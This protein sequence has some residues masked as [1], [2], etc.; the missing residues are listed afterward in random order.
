L[1]EIEIVGGGPAGSAAA[2][3]ALADG[4]RVRIYEKSV[5]PRHRVCGEFLSPEIV[6]VFEE[7]GVTSE[8]FA[9]K[10]A[11]LKRIRLHFGH[12]TASCNLDDPAFG[13]SRYS[14]DHLLLRA[15]A[16]RGAAID[17]VW[18]E[19]RLPAILAHGR[20]RSGP[21]GR[22][23]FGFKAHFRGS[24]DDAVDLFFFGRSYAGVSAVENGMI[25][26]CGL[27]PEELFRT[28]QFDAGSFLPL[29][30]P[31]NER[32]QAMSQVSDWLI[33]GPLVF[34]DSFEQGGPPYQAGDALGFTD[35]F[36]G[37]GI[38]AAVLTGSMAGTAAARGHSFESYL[39]SCRE[40]LRSQYRRS[41]LLR[42][43]VSIGIAGLLAG[44][45]P[46]RALFRWTRPLID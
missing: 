37:S 16:A 35:P 6:S 15:A 45:L 9:A 5:F 27:A 4:A 17:G 32:L 25:N 39:R 13:L 34:G 3:A 12:R 24:T 11:L 33:T 21:R 41:T 1:K 40:A 38:L 22:R 28:H 30:P 44:V 7:L 2:L 19:R 10:P 18:R 31:L 46:V 8:F 43:L 42:P 36:T 26:V 14:L 20:S 23:L 29:H